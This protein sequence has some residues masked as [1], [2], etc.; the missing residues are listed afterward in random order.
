MAAG[1]KNAARLGAHLVFIDESGFLLIPPVRCT[2]APRGQTP[3]LRHHYRHDRVSVIGGLSVSSRRRRLGLYL[4][5]FTENIHG[6]EVATFL[7]HLLAH[8]PGPVI[9][10]W[11]NAGIHRGA[12]VRA[13]CRRVRRLHL[14]ALPAYAPE[15][16]PAEGIWR[17]LKTQM[18]NGRP[19]DPIALLD[20]LALGEATLAASPRHLRACLHASELSFFD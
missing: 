16:N 20:A 11:D 9:V 3:I 5:C 13:L 4:A 6:E 12:A 8:L 19:D 7:R 14:E 18:A 1:K 15:L 10:V 2:W 17:F